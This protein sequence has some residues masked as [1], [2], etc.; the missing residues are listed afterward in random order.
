[1]SNLNFAT[2][3]EKLSNLKFERVVLAGLMTLK[4]SLEWLPA[5]FDVDCFSVDSHKLIFKAVNKLA[6]AG[7]SYQCDMV[8]HELNAEKNMLAAG[9]SQY[10]LEILKNGNAT[11]HNFRDYSKPLVDLSIKRKAYLA[12]EQAREALLD[13][14]NLT[15]VNDLVGGAV[16]DILES[17][18]IRGEKEPQSLEDLGSTY[19]N[20]VQSDLPVRG[21]DTGFM[22]LTNMLTGF[23]P[24][25][26]IIV[27][28]RPGDG[29]TTLAVNIMDAM[30][31]D[32]KLPGIMFSQEMPAE[33]IHH[34]YLASVSE[35]PLTNIRTNSMSFDQKQ[36]TV[37]AQLKLQSTRKLL[38]DDRCAQ[39]PQQMLMF[40]RKQ[41]RK[42]PLGVI[43][44][45][46]LQIMR[47]PEFENN[48][49]TEVSKISNFLK[50]LA[51]EMK[52][53]VVALAQ[54]RRPPEGAVLTRPPNLT[55][56]KESGSIEQDADVILFLHPI[57]S[58]PG[59]QKGHYE[60]H[61]IAGYTELIV[62]K[63]RNGPLGTV[64]L[65]LQGPYSR[66]IELG[67]YYEEERL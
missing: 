38:I 3:F 32:S 22:Q 31:L 63:Q 1:M 54:L 40:C 62:G 9:G 15:P 7:K 45:D 11:R 35:V 42:G 65:V 33:S 6:E 56:L 41:R 61:P 18:D 51:R 50:A 66:F 20:R 28:A 10:L 43:V 46:Y 30:L 59:K 25:E 36:K 64:K 8:E 2:D 67:N 34:R 5:G 23:Y 49:T 52:C 26:L 37:E 24:E 17:L 39:T 16:I 60:P 58:V 29:K 21:I 44:V 19:A 13:S 14:A 48:R 55:D 4:D 47:Y 57:R 53:P 12:V 27:A